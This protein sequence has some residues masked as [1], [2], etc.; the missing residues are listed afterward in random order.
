LLIGVAL[1]AS[2]DLEEGAVFVG[3]VS[4]VEALAANSQRSTGV[5]PGAGVDIAARLDGHRAVV[6]FL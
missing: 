4:N 6:L 2:I 3:A 5:Q 1:R